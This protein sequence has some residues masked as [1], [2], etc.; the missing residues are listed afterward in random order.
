MDASRKL[1]GIVDEAIKL[2]KE[3]QAATKRLEELK[4]RIKEAAEETGKKEFIG[5][6]GRAQVV[7][8]TSWSVKFS[9]LVTWLTKI[10][11]AA[12]ETGKREFI[13]T[14]GRA[15]VVS[16]TSWSVRFSDLV[17]WLTKH[18]KKDLLEL[19]VSVK[20]GEVKSKLGEEVLAEIG[21]KIEKGKAVRFGL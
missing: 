7:S 4:A 1:V 20:H 13:G 9:D 8:V 17:T 16:V 5:T 3:I 11:E 21:E 10:K 6:L 14:L 15:Q 18:K 12:E 2:N 19:F